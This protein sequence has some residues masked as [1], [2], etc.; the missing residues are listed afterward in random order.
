MYN[1]VKKK[2]KIIDEE[3]TKIGKNESEGKIIK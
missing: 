1:Q 2:V 3:Y